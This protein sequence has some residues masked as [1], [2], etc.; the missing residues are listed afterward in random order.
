MLIA[1]CKAL[2]LNNVY[3]LSSNHYIANYVGMMNLLLL[4]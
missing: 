3:G 2:K 4:V 1:Y